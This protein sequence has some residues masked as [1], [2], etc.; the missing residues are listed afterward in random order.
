MIAF[1]DP[2]RHSSAHYGERAEN[3][4]TIFASESVALDILGFDIHCVIL[5]LEKLFL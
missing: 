4:E 3:K 5:N 1:R 2:L